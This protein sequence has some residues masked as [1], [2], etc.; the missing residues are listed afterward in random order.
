MFAK[1]FSMIGIY[2]GHNAIKRQLFTRLFL[3]A[4]KIHRPFH[5]QEPLAQRRTCR[6]S[7]WL[8]LAW[9]GSDWLRVAQIGS[10]R[11]RSAQTRRSSLRFTSL[12]RPNIIPSCAAISSL[13]H[14]CISTWP[15]YSD[16]HDYDQT[17][18]TNRTPH[19]M[20]QLAW[21]ASA[22]IPCH[23]PSCRIPFLID[24][25]HERIHSCRYCSQ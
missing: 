16:I 11:L 2:H 9:I 23:Q 5:G 13:L 1:D 17:K 10:G 7:D 6:S 20:V 12:R 4:V 8:G 18:S 22:T 19:I 14:L 25:R 21:R 24:N 15:F 3:L